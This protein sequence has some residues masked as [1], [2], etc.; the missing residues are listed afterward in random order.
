MDEVLSLMLEHGSLE[1]AQRVAEQRLR[2]GLDVLERALAPL[3]E[4]G[5]VDEIL[6][7]VGELA[8]RP[9]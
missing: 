2:R 9:Y 3:R 8:A 7:L 5:A 4:Q 1:Y 6:D